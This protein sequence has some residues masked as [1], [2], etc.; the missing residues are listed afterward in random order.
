LKVR[1]LRITTV[2]GGPFESKVLKNYNCCCDPFEGKLLTHYNFCWGL[3]E[4][5]EFRDI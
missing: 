5:M 4:S 1:Y 3:F 2:V